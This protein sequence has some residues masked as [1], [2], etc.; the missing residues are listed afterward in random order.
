[1]TSKVDAD[2]RP[3]DSLNHYSKGAVISFLHTRVAGIR[4]LD[5]YPG[6]RR[7]AIA[8]LPGGGLTRAEATLDTPYG[9]IGSRWRRDGG[10][11]ELDVQVPPGTRALVTLPDGQQA[12]LQPPGGTLVGGAMDGGAAVLGAA[13]RESAVPGAAEQASA[14]RPAAAVPGVAG[15]VTLVSLGAAVTAAAGMVAADD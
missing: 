14:A 4:L 13:V 8:P 7:F 5:G 3:H 11:I 12:E 15:Q 1:M 10:R 9:R 2:G 6:Y